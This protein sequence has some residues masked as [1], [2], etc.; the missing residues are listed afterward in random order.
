MAKSAYRKNSHLGAILITL[1]GLSMIVYAAAFIVVSLSNLIE[2]GLSAKE[3]G[4][5]QAEI[6][7]FSPSVYNYI[8]HVQVNLGAF[9][10]ATGL[11]VAA[12]G[13]FGVRKG[14]NWAWW[15]VLAMTLTW[16]F[17]G[18]PVHYAYGFD[19]LGHLGFPY[20]A[21]ISIGSG[22]IISRIGR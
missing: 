7:T 12:A 2:I 5:S 9:I 19:A 17:I 3:L 14:L 13:W 6:Q 18:I 11:A 1:A 15:A 20:L 21:V 16:A 22:L 4:K 10:A 8:N